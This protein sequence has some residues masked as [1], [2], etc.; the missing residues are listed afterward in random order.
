MSVC[1]T[2]GLGLWVLELV[3]DHR[4]VRLAVGLELAGWWVGPGNKWSK[5]YCLFTSWTLQSLDARGPGGSDGS[6]CILVSGARILSSTRPYPRAVVAS[7]NLIQP[8][9]C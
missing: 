4:W 6:A 1:W 7:G 5:G 2:M 9:C 3:P 8:A